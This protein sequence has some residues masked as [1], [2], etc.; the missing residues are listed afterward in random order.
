MDY[1]YLIFADKLMCEDAA[2]AITASGNVEHALKALQRYGILIA[3]MRYVNF[4]FGI[5][6][7]WTTKE[8][9]HLVDHTKLVKISHLKNCDI[10]V[11]L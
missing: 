1:N 11:F 9:A 2:K 7:H 10:V 5:N 6:G 3:V 4:R 8:M